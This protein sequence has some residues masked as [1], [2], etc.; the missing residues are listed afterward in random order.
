MAASKM[1]VILYASTINITPRIYS[2]LYTLNS[3]LL[4]LCIFNFKPFLHEKIMHTCFVVYG[5]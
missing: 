5:K 3:I 4:L 1:A 2:A